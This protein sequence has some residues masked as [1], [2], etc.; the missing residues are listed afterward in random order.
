MH[1]AF[2]LF[3][4]LFKLYVYVFFQ[5]FV[6]NGCVHVIR[7]HFGSSL[8]QFGT[9]SP[10]ISFLFAHPFFGSPLMVRMLCMPKSIEQQYLKK[11]SQQTTANKQTI[12]D[13][14]RLPNY[15]SVQVALCTDGGSAITPLSVAHGLRDLYAV[16]GIR[17]EVNVQPFSFLSGNILQQQITLHNADIFW[18]A[19][20]HHV[21]P[22]LREALSL[23]DDETGVN[24]LAAQVRSRVQYDQ[25]PYVGVCGGASMASSPETCVYGCGLDLM[26]GREI[27]YGSQSSV[28]MIGNRL[29]FTE[30]VGFAVLLSAARFD[31]V[32]F[33]CVKNSGQLWDFADSHSVLLQ[34]IVQ[35]LASE[36]KEFRGPTDEPWF[37]NLRGYY[38]L[39]DSD[40]LHLV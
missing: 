37:F 31:A 2:T 25:M 5:T 10:L 21:P 36:W 34:S 30:K 20:V 1:I 6:Y 7:I 27:Y 29:A 12:A 9:C 28:N 38:C 24:D 23:T 14:L 32:C 35:Q 11:V 33:P 40:E 13:V 22:R 3:W 18:F 26:Q 8:A 4:N 15:D 16:L 19:G 39:S 17:A